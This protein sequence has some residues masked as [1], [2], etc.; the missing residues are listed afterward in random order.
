MWDTIDQQAVRASPNK[1]E[2]EC[3]VNDSYSIRVWAQYFAVSILS[4]S[5]QNSIFPTAKIKTHGK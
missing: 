4:G 5:R 2:A 3:R 1:I